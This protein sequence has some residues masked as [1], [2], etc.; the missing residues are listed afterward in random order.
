[1]TMND[2]WGFKKKDHNWKSAQTLIHNLVDIAAKGGNYLLNVGPTPEGLIPEASVERLREMGEWMAVNA[3]V[4][5]N[6]RMW[7]QYKEGEQI[8]Y[9]VDAKG[10][11]YATCLEWP[12]EE[13]Q[14][15]YVRPREGSAVVMLGYETPL[16]WTYDAAEG[17]TIRLP[18]ALQDEQNR[19]CRYAWAFR[20]EGAYPE[21][22]A[23]PSFHS[24]GREVEKL[25]IFA[26][27]TEVELHSATPGA[28]IFYTL[29]GSRP[30]AKAKRYTG[31]IRLSKTTVAKAI[32]VKDGLV[33]SP[34]SEASFRRSR[35]NGIQL[36]HPY[37]EKYD[38]GGPLGLIDGL[39]GSTTFA[40]GAWQGF[41]GEDFQATIDLGS[42]Q[43]I[44]HIK[45]T[46]LRDIGAWIFAPEGVQF[47]VSEDGDVFY[48]LSY[49]AVPRVQP[50]DPVQVLEFSQ[51]VNRPARYIRITARNIGI[52]PEWHAGAGGKAWL[53]VDE[54]VVE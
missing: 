7:H 33:N 46:F 29:D 1:M 53:F 13:L 15:K 54:V 6:S 31:P 21:V 39:H 42:L 14:L 26:E 2:S 49:F 22:A 23:A 17:L 27:T 3:P 45:T 51:E 41:E 50:D 11:V 37:S 25:D 48:P 10:R 4:V 35:F 40:D 32:A 36:L 18:A 20:I 52:C 19:P 34:A 30:T 12:G 8:R 44:N 43:P 9:T 38:A 16:Q 24:R 28:S 47:E 5:H